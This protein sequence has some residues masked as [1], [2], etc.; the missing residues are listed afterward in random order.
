MLNPDDSGC[1]G[2][3]ILGF[4]PSLGSVGTVPAPLLILEGPEQDGIRLRCL[5]ERPF[6]TVRLLWTDGNGENLTGIALP[7]DTGNAGSSLLLRPGSGNSASCRIIDPQLR[8]SSESS[9]VI[10][11]IFF[12]ATS[13]WLPAFVMLL[14]IGIFL[15]L[16]AFYKLRRN[17]QI[18]ARERKAQ[19]EIQEEIEDLKGE[20]EDEMEKFQ[21]ENQRMV[22]DIEQIQAQL[23]FRRAQSHAVPLTLDEL[24]KHPD[25]AI[26]GNSR[27]LHAHPGPEPHPKA[28]A[29]AR[30]GFS[31]GK[32]YWEVEVGDGS[33]WEL[34]VISQEIRDWLQNNGMRFPEERVPSLEYS[35]GEFRLPGGKLERNSGRCRVLGVFLNQESRE[36]HTLSFLDAEGKQLLGSL[37]LK[38]SGNLFPFFNPGS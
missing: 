2:A 17:S 13:P 27:I 31:Q 7:T 35:Q 10:A 19:Q 15:V 38:L 3:G 1:P 11:D 14:I 9:V 4:F 12:P 32:H 24:C 30:E 25:L 8:T 22:K 28:V 21:K 6:A 16:A 23:D 33:H 5:S 26:Q 37:P 34:G 18:I 20:L 29:V 36:S